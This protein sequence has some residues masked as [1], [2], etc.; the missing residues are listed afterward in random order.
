M[1]L[2][3]AGSREMGVEEVGM[4]GNLEEDRGKKM[5]YIVRGIVN[6]IA[7]MSFIVRFYGEI[8][9]IVILNNVLHFC[10]RLTIWLCDAC[11]STTVVILTVQTTGK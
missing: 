6:Y 3:L 5:R 1:V 10:S 2:G 9:D 11:D 8:K 4:L 7:C